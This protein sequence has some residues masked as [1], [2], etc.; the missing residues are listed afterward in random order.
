MST[1]IEFLEYLQFGTLLILNIGLNAN[2]FQKKE[3]TLTEIRV[4]DSIVL[5]RNWVT[6][7]T[8]GYKLFFQN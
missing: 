3:K 1:R 7:C 4:L 8:I 5:E 2:N 6:R